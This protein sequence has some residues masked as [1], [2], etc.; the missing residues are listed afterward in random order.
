[1]INISEINLDYESLLNSNLAHLWNTFKLLCKKIDFNL[2]FVFTNVEYF[3]PEGFK[4]LLQLGKENQI[5]SIYT[6]NKILRPT[7]IDLLTEFDIKKKLNYF[8]FKELYSILKQRVLLTFSHGIDDELIKYITDLIYEQYV[9][10]PGKG[11][12]ILRDFYPMLKSKHNIKNCELIELCQNHF[13]QIQLHDEFSMLNYISEEEF[14]NIIY[15]DNLSSHFISKMNYYISLKELKELFHIT[16]ES[17]EY[18]KNFNEFQRLVK[19]LLNVGILR[20][21]KKKLQG[22]K[23]SLLDST[24][25]SD[26]YFMVI[27]PNQLKAIID[28]IFQSN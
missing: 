26:S 8:S 5:T 1:L 6:I 4:K 27:S 28:T 2:F 24:P 7:T 11:I 17:L 25:S 3:E 15:L 20:P 9:P 22:Q 19:D 16:C 18:E 21:S 13:E 23:T 10:V 12:E 14:L